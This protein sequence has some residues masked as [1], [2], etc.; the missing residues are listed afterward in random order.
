MVAGHAFPHLEFRERVWSLFL[1]R[2]NYD[3]K[4]PLV[5]KLLL[6]LERHEGIFLLGPIMQEILDGI[7]NET[8]FYK[9]IDYFSVFSLLELERMDYIDASRLRNHCRSKGVQASPVD[10]WIA[11]ACI[12]RNYPLLTAD[13]DFHL[14]AQHSQLDLE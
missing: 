1:R 11:A 14:I 10:F 5:Q 2:K 12:R 8:Q 3:S 7:R 9:L 6:C 13:K 4:D